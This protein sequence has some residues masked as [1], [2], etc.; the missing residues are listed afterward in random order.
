M[1][2]G[3][4]SGRRAAVV[5]LDACGA[6]ELPDSAAYGDAGA[7]TLEHLASAAGG[8][9]LPSLQRLG[10]GNVLALEGVPPVPAPALHGRLAPLGPGKDSISGHWELMG[11]VASAPPLTYPEGLPREVVE[12][13]RAT[14][15]RE[16]LCAARYDGL[17]A[18]DDFGDEALREGAVI[19]YTSQDSVLQLAAHVDRVSQAQLHAACDA[20]REALPGP[21]A[22][23]RIIARP[24][25]GCPG[26]F[27]R[28]DGRRDFALAPGPTYLDALQR[29]GV[30]VHGVGK[31]GQLFAGRGVDHDHHAPTSAPAIAATTEL[32]DSL[33]E[34]LVF[35]N[36]VDTDQVHGH[37]HDVAGFAAALEEVDAA[38]ERWLGLLREGDLLV[39]TADHGCDPLAAHTDH[40]R[41][42][43]PLLA[44]GAG[45]RGARHD[46]P[47]ADVGASVHRWL[48]GRDAPELPGTPFVAS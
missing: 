35:A 21:D 47:M 42:H 29:A 40:T 27:A 9:R 22:V 32:L 7:S 11:H 15:G 20:V 36:L 2:S 4:A 10:L 1:P 33:E 17:A 23:G 25:A 28:T 39:L 16:I 12:L 8:L 13:L 14:T 43:V 6:G 41:E 44:V 19:A 5:V 34:G 18:I 38:V 30:P 45:L 46:G 3:P 24:F 26:A 37:R 31:V 48:T